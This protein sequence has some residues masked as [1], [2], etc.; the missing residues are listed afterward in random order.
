MAAPFVRH[1]LVGAVPVIAVDIKSEVLDRAVE[2]GA[3]FACDAGDPGLRDNIAEITGGRMLD[4][5]FDAVGLKSTFEKALDCIAVGGRLVD[6]GMSAETP[7]VG[8]TSMFALTKKH[9]LGHLGYQNV[10]IETLAK[11]LS[12]GR[13][14]LSRS[15]SDIVALEDVRVGIEKLERQ[16]GNPIRILIKP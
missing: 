6:V 14:D 7:S 5:A 13:L 8:P 4:A 2:L 10:D 12:M 11:L 1:A 16:E 9:V 3:D 15:I